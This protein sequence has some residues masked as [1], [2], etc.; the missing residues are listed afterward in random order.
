MASFLSRAS[1]RLAARAPHPGL[2]ALLCTVPTGRLITLLGGAPEAG[3]LPSLPV[4]SRRAAAQVLLLA[5][6]SR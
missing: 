3:R 6:A 2:G 1:S 5:S 4:L